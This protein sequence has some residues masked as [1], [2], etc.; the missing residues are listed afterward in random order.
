MSAARPLEGKE[1]GWAGGRPPQGTVL[2]REAE[3]SSRE[4]R[5]VHDKAPEPGAAS[6]TQASPA[7]W[8]GV[9]AGRS[10]CYYAPARGSNLLLPLTARGLQGPGRPA[11]TTRTAGGRR[12]NGLYVARSPAR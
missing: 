5:Q 8:G 7:P 9:A 4:R 12:V 1:R 3:S 2:L 10:C 6:P 11:Q